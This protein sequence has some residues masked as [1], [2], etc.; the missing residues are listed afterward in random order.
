MTTQTLPSISF[1]RAVRAGF[2]AGLISAGLNNIWSLLAQALGAVAPP[3]FAFAVTVSSI[4]PTV[5]GAILFF[6]LVKWTSKGQLIWM[7]IAVAF[8]LLSCIP[9]FGTTLPDGNAAPERFTL[10]TLP[11][12]LIAGAV[13][14][15]GIPKWSK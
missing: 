6:A 9:T 8:T 10:L 1:G 14:I 2:I 13:A 3:M 5:I 4:M 7:V 15:W 12:H 11:M